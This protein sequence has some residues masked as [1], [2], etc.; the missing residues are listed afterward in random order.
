MSINLTYICSVNWSHNDV[1]IFSSHSID[2]LFMLKWCNGHISIVCTYLLKMVMFQHHAMTIWRWDGMW[3]GA[4]VGCG[5]CG[6]LRMWKK[7]QFNLNTDDSIHDISDILIIPNSELSTMI[8]MFSY[9]F[10]SKHFTFPCHPIW[11]VRNCAEWKKALTSL[12]MT[13]N[14]NS[15]AMRRQFV[16]FFALKFM[17][18]YGKWRGL[19]TFAVDWDLKAFLTP[20]FSSTHDAIYMNISIRS[21]GWHGMI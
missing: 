12:H 18:H 10:T 5:W 6:E 2:S 1:L 19:C 21:F 7:M 11:L 15:I 13:W 20:I 9:A 3:S 4:F 14:L 16:T 8:F 17:P